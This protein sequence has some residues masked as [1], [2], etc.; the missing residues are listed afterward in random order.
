MSVCD[1][2]GRFELTT[3]DARDGAPAGQYAITVELRQPQQR[4]EEMVRDG[5][6]VLPP[7]YADASRSPLR[8]TV[9]EGRNEV[10]PLVI[11]GP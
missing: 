6:N 4:G 9:V 5:P 3:Y 8:Y 2:Q 1:A 11:S 7:K 10:P